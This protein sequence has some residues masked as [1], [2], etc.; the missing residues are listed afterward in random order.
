MFR[1]K[2]ERSFNKSAEEWMWLIRLALKFR[3]ILATDEVRVIAQ[4]D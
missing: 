2:R 3:V 4:F 1:I